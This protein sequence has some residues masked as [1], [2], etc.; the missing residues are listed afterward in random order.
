MN[1][2]NVTR[3][4]VTIAMGDGPS[5]DTP[6]FVTNDFSISITMFDMT[7]ETR[8]NTLFLFEKVR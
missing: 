2:S 8:D 1:S 7:C 5:K 3:D 4:L 6:F